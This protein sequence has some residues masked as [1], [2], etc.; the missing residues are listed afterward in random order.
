MLPYVFTRY[1]VSNAINKSHFSLKSHSYSPHL[2]KYQ[3]EQVA[4]NLGE[5]SNFLYLAYFDAY[6][7]WVEVANLASTGLNTI[8]KALLM[9]VTTFG[10]P[11]KIVTNR[12]SPFYSGN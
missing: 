7:R 9:L 10:A 8:R 11:Q 4:M 3:F 2:Q 12:G 5:I 6:S 1:D